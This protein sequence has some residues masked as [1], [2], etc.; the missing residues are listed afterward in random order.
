M[1]SDVVCKGQL[2]NVYSVLVR[3]GLWCVRGSWLICT[4]C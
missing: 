3:K 4:G 1:E 2:V